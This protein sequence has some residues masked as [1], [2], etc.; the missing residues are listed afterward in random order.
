MADRKPLP[1]LEVLETLFH[2]DVERGLLIR[3]TDQAWSAKKGAIVGSVDGKGYL[4]VCIS[5]KLY[6]VHRLI[7]FMHFGYDPENG[8][9]HEDLD[10]RNNRPSNLRPA[11]TQQNMGNI[12]PP[13]HN[14]SGVKGVSKNS[15]SGLWHAQIR[16]NRKQTC[17][18]RFETIEEAAEAY[19]AAA[20]RV[21]GE[22]ARTAND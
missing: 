21:F 9:D 1:P 15:R 2:L 14:T 5:R 19:A 22:F 3:K 18:G 12:A 10:R 13:K 20:K 11:S 6:R 16:I 4:H 7:F 17:I 8:I